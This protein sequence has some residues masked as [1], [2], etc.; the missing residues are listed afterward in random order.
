M[1]EH[2]PFF[3]NTLLEHLDWFAE[4]GLKAR[5]WWRDDDAVEATPALDRLMAIANAFEIDVALAVIPNEVKE[6]LADRLQDERH[7]V[8]FQHGFRHQNFQLRERG[9]K[10]AEFGARRLPQ[11][12]LRELTEGRKRLGALFGDRFVPVLVPPWNRISPAV[13]RAL[14][15]TGLAGVSTFTWMHPYARSRLQSHIDV[16]KWK[17]GRTFIGY[18]CAGLRLDLQLARR[19]NAPDE[20]IG[21]LTH[22]LDH[23]EACF[24]FLM[25]LYSIIRRH[26][27]AECPGVKALALETWQFPPA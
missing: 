18:H 2:L 17:K 3:R 13:V 21:I 8:V 26:P 20:P 5:F 10:A 7:A 4:R 25:E 12:A 1:T 22:H 19:R 27:G 11:E 23:D 6:S 9:E 14:P 24:E 16:I 15:A